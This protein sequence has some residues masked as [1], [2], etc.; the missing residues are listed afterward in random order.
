VPKELLDRVLATNVFWS[1]HQ[2]TPK[3]PDR[4][5]SMPISSTEKITR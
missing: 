2:A 4:G 3:H 5:V 1:E